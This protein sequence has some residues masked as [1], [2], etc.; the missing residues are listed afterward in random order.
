MTSAWK[1]KS[2]AF[3]FQIELVLLLALTKMRNS[4][5]KWLPLVL[6]L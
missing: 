1:E 4:L 2:L 3:I 6:D 5:M